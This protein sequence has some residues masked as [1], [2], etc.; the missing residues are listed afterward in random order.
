MSRWIDISIGGRGVTVP[1]FQ[2][3]A[4]FRDYSLQPDD[5][6]YEWPACFVVAA[7]LDREAQAWGDWLASDYTRRHPDS[8]FLWSYLDVTPWKNGEV[9]R[10]MA[11][12]A[13]SDE[14]IGW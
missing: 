7:A 4:W 5:E 12:E 13:V 1:D 3:V 9:P 8:V 6:G 11:G 14:I 10:V 2:Y